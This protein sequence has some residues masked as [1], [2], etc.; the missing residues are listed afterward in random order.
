MNSDF[1]KVNIF[2]DYRDRFNDIPGKYI[3][4]NYV[5]E[6]NMF[7]NHCEINMGRVYREGYKRYAMPIDE[8]MVEFNLKKIEI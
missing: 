4:K 5:K 6:V 1:V 7:Q 3:N 2:V 8:C